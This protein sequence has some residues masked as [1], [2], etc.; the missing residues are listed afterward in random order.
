LQIRYP[1]Y[2]LIL[3]VGNFLV[4][5]PGVHFIKFNR[6]Q[7]KK[8]LQLSDFTPLFIEELGWDYAKGSPIYL[9][10]NDENYTQEAQIICSLGLFPGQLTT[11]N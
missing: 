2:F 11:D 4:H 3:K 9:K 10:V 5:I 7:V 6:G 1:A 8:Y